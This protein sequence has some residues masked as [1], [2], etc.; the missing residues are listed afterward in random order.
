[1]LMFVYHTRIWPTYA[2]R[3]SLSMPPGI[4]CAGEPPHIFTVKIAKIALRAVFRP[5]SRLGTPQACFAALS[6]SEAKIEPV[7]GV[8]RFWRRG[9]GPIE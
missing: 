4:L 8:H 1:M 5:L 2:K 9:G 3:K 7:F 6:G